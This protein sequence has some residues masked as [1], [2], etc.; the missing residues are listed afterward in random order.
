LKGKQMK[1]TTYLMVL[2]SAVLLI[3]LAVKLLAEQVVVKPDFSIRKYESQTVIYTIYRGPY[4]TIG[5]PIGQL[6]AMAAQKKI[7]PC[8][9]PSLVYLNNPYSTLQDSPEKHCLT[10]IRIPVNQNAIQQSG[11]F[12]EMTD[13]KTLRA[14]DVAV[15][16]KQIGQR[17]YNALFKALYEKIAEEGYRSSD[18]A[19]EVFSTNIAGGNYTQIKSEIMV[20][21][22]K[23]EQGKN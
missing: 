2:L 16:K 12:G 3:G 15:I 5:K 21:V 8:G 18:N 14:V 6:Y 11:T 19:F 9:P 17:D 20:P 4:E 7:T 13:I 22:V 10:E 1:K 23:I